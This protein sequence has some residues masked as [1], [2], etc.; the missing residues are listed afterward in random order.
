VLR[1]HGGFGYWCA[2]LLVCVYRGT[3][4][5][6]VLKMAFAEGAALFKDPTHPCSSSRLFQDWRTA[7]ATANTVGEKETRSWEGQHGPKREKRSSREEDD[8]VGRR[9]G[10]DGPT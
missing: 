6:I 3:P 5:E 1:G 4:S 2:L 9:S 10:R 7:S 8:R